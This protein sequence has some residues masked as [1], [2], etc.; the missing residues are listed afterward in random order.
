MN[1]LMRTSDEAV[2]LLREGGVGVMPTDTVYG[3]VAEASDSRA[4]ERFYALKHRERKP[5]TVIA[6]S[7]GQLVKLGVDERYLRR[8][9][10]W[11]PNSLSVETPLSEALAY[12]HQGTGHCAWRV[13]ADA[14]LRQMLEQTGPL[15]TS[16][17][18]QPGKPPAVNV[19]EAWNYFGD[20]VDFYVDGGDL[21]GRL[22]STVIRLVDDDIV[23]VREGAVKA[24]ELELDRE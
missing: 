16:S 1:S 21:S 12:L 13:V 18:N 19:D 10:R 23:V 15:V 9:E 24:N 8:V 20:G 5:G 3:L 17:A 6:A 11:W 4:V 7:V 2:G 22:P 14:G